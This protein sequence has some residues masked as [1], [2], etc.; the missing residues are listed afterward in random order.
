MLR[1][2]LIPGITDTEENLR[3]ISDIV[4]DAPVELL[5]YNPLAGAKY[6][7]FGMSYPL[8]DRTNRDEDFTGYFANA[9]IS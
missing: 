8:S 2:P 9:T 6:A 4:G 3:G 7:T 5:R 1:V